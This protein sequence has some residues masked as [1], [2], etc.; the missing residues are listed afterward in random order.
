[1]KN[2]PPAQ[3]ALSQGCRFRSRRNA[4]VVS[5][6][7]R[8]AHN[9]KNI[10]QVSEPYVRR[11]PLPL[12]ITTMLKHQTKGALFS[13][14]VVAVPLLLTISP[15]KLLALWR[16][17]HVGSYAFVSPLALI[18]GLSYVY[19]AYERYKSGKENDNVKL[20]AQSYLETS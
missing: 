20:M 14:S 7:T 16:D 1:M 11:L 3:S 10:V 15:S 4:Y 5:N 9:E 8:I 6:C 19:V 17:I 2:L 12:L 18:L 13:V